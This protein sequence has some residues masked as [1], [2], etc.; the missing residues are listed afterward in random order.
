VTT[1]YYIFSA[2]LI[3]F[4]L[5]SFRGGLDYLGHFQRDL[6]KP[7]CGFTPP[8]TVIVPCKGVDHGLAENLAAFA[9]Q[10]YPA[11]QIIFVVEGQGD[12]AAEIIQHLSRKGGEGAEVVVA[13]RAAVSGQ[14]VE[15]LR[16]AVL[17]ADPGTQVFVFADSDVR[18]AENWLR[19]LVAPLAD[20]RIGAATGY[21]WFVTDK[22]NLATEMR[23]AWNA[24][25][26]SALGP[27][28]R[29]N[30]CWGGSMAIRREVFE[31][32]GIRE[33]WQSTLSDDF[34]VT[35]AMNEACMPI[36]FVPQAFVPSPGRC[37]WLELL[38]F[39]NRQM[40]I[41]RVYRAKL[42]AM[43]FFGSALFIAVMIASAILAISSPPGPFIW[44]FAIFTLI[45][46]T[47]LS[48]GKAWLRSKAVRLALPG[49]NDAL[50][51]QT[52]YQ[53]TL[54][55]F[56]PVVY[57][58]NCVAALFSRRISWRGIDYLMVSAKE[59]RVMYPS[60]RSA[61]RK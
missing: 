11:Y 26:A 27:D 14:K 5:R 52:P 19:S 8:A 47:L 54:W 28:T 44:F 4:S 57:L 3:Y 7:D 9:D 1:F 24:S 20:E 59:T 51:R 12:P 58:I 61:K 30:F 16:E 25:I 39:T 53:L 46:V 43:S 18:P 42:W 17:H 29:S 60:A 34:T 21:R 31:R 50:R 49:Q 10:N 13:P 40:K 2:L 55:L 32:L 36:V 35:R 56:T 6:A 48:L 15:N 23:S 45:S 22:T 38:E 33:R 41:T 37:S